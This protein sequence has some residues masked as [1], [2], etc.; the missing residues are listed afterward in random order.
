MITLRTATR[1]FR[2]NDWEAVYDWVK[3][4]A[5]KNNFRFTQRELTAKDMKQY[6]QQQLSNDGSQYIN[7]VLYDLADLDQKYIG[8]VSLKKIDLQDQ[9]AE[10]AI[11]ISDAA[12]RGKG[13]GQEALYLICKYGFSTL[14]LH[15]IYLTCVAH[16]QSAI[17][18]YQNFG[19]VHEGL[20]KE[21]IFQNGQFYDE[22]LMGILKISFTTTY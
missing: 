11:V 9:N 8:T 4:P 16:N 19:F 20:R 15:K 17:K 10:L 14:S 13:Y 7:F 22:V 6:V 12:Y 5:I 1:P 3:D 18:A 21:Q 2:E